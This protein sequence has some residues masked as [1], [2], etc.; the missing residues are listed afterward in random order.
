MD[1]SNHQK[2]QDVTDLTPKQTFAQFLKFTL[3]SISAG[4]IQILSFTL[5]SWVLDR[6]FAGAPWLTSEYGLAYFLALVLS[7]LWNFTIN[8]KFTFKSAANVPKAMFK[9]F[10]FYCIFTPLSIWWGVALERIGWND[11]AILLPTM[12]LNM[13]TEYLFCLF[14]V[15]R[16]NLN[17]AAK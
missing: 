4:I 3:F 13:I 8:R 9:V 2:P 16:H 7:V 12:V 17:T 11:F 10:L 5:F 6:W 1:Q 15:Y 14:F